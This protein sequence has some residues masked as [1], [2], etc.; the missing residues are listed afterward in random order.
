MMKQI[1]YKAFLHIFQRAP[2]V[3]ETEETCICSQT[4]NLDYTSRWEQISKTSK[5]LAVIPICEVLVLDPLQGA[6]E[7]LKAEMS[8][9]RADTEIALKGKQD[10]L[11]DLLMIGHS[12]EAKVVDVQAKEPSDDIPF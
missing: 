6:V 1:E 10:R 12:Q 2:Q 9:I 7:A 5:L 4:F 11:N 3:W 8:E